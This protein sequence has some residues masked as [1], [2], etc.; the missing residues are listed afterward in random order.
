[1]AQCDFLFPKIQDTM[2][3]KQ[4]EEVDAI[5]P[6]TTQKVLEIP[7]TENEQCFH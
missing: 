6:N 5:K 2:K 3:G 4:F 1:M 7:N